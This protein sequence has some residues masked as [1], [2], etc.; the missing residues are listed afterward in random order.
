MDF[1]H[2]VHHSDAAFHSSFHL[3]ENC[4]R[5]KS[6]TANCARPCHA[7]APGSWLRWPIRRWCP[8]REKFVTRQLNLCVVPKL[9]VKVDPD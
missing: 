4:D 5:P 7:G 2:A 1:H 6:K 9:V 8:P 3:S